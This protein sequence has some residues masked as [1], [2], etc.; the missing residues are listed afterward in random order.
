[1]ALGCEVGKA[2]EQRTASGFYAKY[3][4]GVGLD[5]GYK[6][7]SDGTPISGAVGVD[8]GYPDYDGVHLPFPT[9]SQDYIF[10]SH[11]L[12]HVVDPIACLQE[13]HRVVKVGGYLIIAVPHHHLFEKKKEMPSNKCPTHLRFYTPS[14]FL[15]DIE[16][17]LTPNTYRIRHFMDRDDGFDYNRDPNFYGAHTERFE[18]ECVLQKLAKPWWD[19][20]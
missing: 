19:L 6:G 5:I 9:Q 2:H 11:C 13:W 8:L 14:G 3:A 12:E 1:M 4:T 17:A 18:I 7:D 16:R 10:S 20:E 15:S